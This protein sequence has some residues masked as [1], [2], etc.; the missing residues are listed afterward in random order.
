MQ[1]AICPFEPGRDSRKWFDDFKT[2]GDEDVKFTAMAL[3]SF[4]PL[5]HWLVSGQFG[6]E[7][8]VSSRQGANLQ[9]ALTTLIQ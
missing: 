3:I 1:Q 4:L 6:S 9:N 8:F 2:M 5:F 7:R